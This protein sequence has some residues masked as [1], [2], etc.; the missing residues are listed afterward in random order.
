MIFC[1]D[2]ASIFPLKLHEIQR[3]VENIHVD[4]NGCWIWT[5]SRHSAGYGDISLRGK[6]WLTHRLVYRLFVGRIN[7]GHVIDHL[8]RNRLCC[9]PEH[10]ESV[11][12]RTNSRRG[13]IPWGP[14]HWLSTRTHCIHG[15][16]LDGDNVLVRTDRGHTSRTCRACAAIR[17][18]AYR[19]RKREAAKAALAHVGCALAH[20]G[21][22][23][24]MP[25]GPS[26]AARRASPNTAADT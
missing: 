9:N 15:H 24:E 7:K 16:P 14:R 4:K 2:Y 3:I 12:P 10:L 17:T 6:H 1:R 5:G 19:K 23:L 18:A 22:T 20:A 11:T 21:E 25:E 26:T 8:C 13:D